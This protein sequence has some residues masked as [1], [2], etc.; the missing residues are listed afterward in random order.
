[1]AYR[2]LGQTFIGRG[3]HT[4]TKTVKA[5]YSTNDRFEAFRMFK[6]EHPDYFIRAMG[7]AEVV[8]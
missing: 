5:T 4:E 7:P 6:A 8:Q 1:M 3:D 2:V